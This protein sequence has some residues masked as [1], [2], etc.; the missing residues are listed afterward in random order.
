MACSDCHQPARAFT[1]GLARRRR[2]FAPRPQ[3]ADAH[4]CRWAALVRL[5]WR[6]TTIYGRK[7]CDR[8]LTQA[9]WPA[10]SGTWR[11]PSAAPTTSPAATP[12][13]LRVRPRR[14]TRRSPSTSR[15]RWRRIRK[16]SSPRPRRSTNS[17][18]RWR[19]A[20]KRRL[21][22]IRRPRA[23]GS[24]S[25]SAKAIAV[26][27]TAVR[28]SPTANFT[29]SASRFSRRRGESTRDDTRESGICARA[30]TTC[31]V[32]S[33]TTRNARPRPARGTWRSS[34]ATMASSRCLRCAT[35]RVPHPTCTTEAWPACAMS[36]GTIRTW[37]RTGCTPT[38]NAS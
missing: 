10:A 12:A 5:G 14:T 28:T 20:T 16:R 24:R 37:T 34:T 2:T 6:A 19:V 21:P 22:A 18:R 27:A 7:A 17:A 38:A 35:S 4:Q 29:T 25:S 36:C 23:A 9:K 26:S 33:M 30:A 1:D 8:C 31:S 13:P 15:R 3:H 11:A 32:R